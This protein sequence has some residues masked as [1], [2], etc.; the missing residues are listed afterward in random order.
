MVDNSL[1]LMRLC[2]D[3]EQRT[4]VLVSQLTLFGP[5]ALLAS[6]QRKRNQVFVPNAR[7]VSD[8]IFK[9][10]TPIRQVSASVSSG[11]AAPAS[12]RESDG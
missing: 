11:L 12:A 4:P 8:R 2:V 3:T 1:L 9:P 10:H 6:M 5:R 7:A